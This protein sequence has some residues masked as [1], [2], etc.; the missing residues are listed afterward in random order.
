MYISRF[1]YLCLAGIWTHDLHVTGLMCYPLS[2]PDWTELKIYVYRIRPW[3]RLVLILAVI[4]CLVAMVCKKGKFLELCCYF[5]FFIF[6]LLCCFFY[7]L[8]VRCWKVWQK[9]EK[10]CFRESAGILQNMQDKVCVCEREKK[11]EREWEREWTRSTIKIFLNVKSLVKIF[12][13]GPD[14]HCS[15]TFLKWLK[16]LKST[17]I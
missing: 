6:F 15:Q 13:G 10:M 3:I 14:L 7:M 11:R 2:Y 12:W 1:H 17:L 9:K 5:Y 16:T 8:F 4:L